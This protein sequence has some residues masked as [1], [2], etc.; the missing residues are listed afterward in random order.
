MADAAAWV[1]DVAGVAGND[2]EMKLG[3][4]L[5]SSGAVVEA[6]VEGVGGGGEVRSQVL[7][8]PVGAPDRAV[9]TV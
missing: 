3:P 9:Q 7:L 6:E 1:G 4:S 5:A 8:G 2:V